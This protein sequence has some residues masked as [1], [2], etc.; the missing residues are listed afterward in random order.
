MRDRAIYNIQWRTLVNLLLPIILRK[1]VVSNLLY[2]FVSPLRRLHREFIGF[3]GRTEQELSYNSQVCYLRKILNDKFDNALRRITIEDGRMY[4]PQWVY[5]RAE[6]RPQCF[7][8]RMLH[9]RTLIGSGGTFVV[10]VPV[11]L[12]PYTPAISAAA[13]KYRLA[14]KTPV[15]QYF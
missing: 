8:L 13:D 3:R 11:A 6:A 12:Q 5:R 14:T 2:V 7:G 10:R 1:P 4:N 9:R 15:I